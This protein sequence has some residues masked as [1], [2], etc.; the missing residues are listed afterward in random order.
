MSPT[1]RGWGR[2]GT[3]SHG[4]RWD[5]LTVTT[6]KT[7]SV[8]TEVCTSLRNPTFRKERLRPVYVRSAVGKDP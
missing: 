3:E 1:D 8:G 2:V 7:F 4:G 6:G 5:M